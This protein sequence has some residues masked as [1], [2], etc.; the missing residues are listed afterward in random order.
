M[1]ST[2]TKY[3][4]EVQ[5][6]QPKMPMRMKTELPMVLRDLINAK[7]IDIK[8]NRKIVNELIEILENAKP[9]LIF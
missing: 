1:P 5:Y 2:D 9:E 4:S 7:F 6:I 3:L 8:W